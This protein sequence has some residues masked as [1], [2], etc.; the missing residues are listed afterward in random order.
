[1]MY[2]A[3]RPLETA[4]VPLLSNDK[5][6]EVGEKMET[7]KTSKNEAAVNRVSQCNWTLF[8][9]GTITGIILIFVL[10]SFVHLIAVY[11]FKGDAA[12]LP[13]LT[14]NGEYSILHWI[15]CVATAASSYFIFSSLLDYCFQLSLHRMLLG[16][17]R[18]AE[19]QE[20]CDDGDKFGFY[21]SLGNLVSKDQQT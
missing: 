8:K 2:S 14:A 16:E 13:S 3:I 21:F 12:R 17:R 7:L 4:R 9:V 20:C 15:V 5:I 10:Y 1:M 6:A 19:D 18:I 11:L